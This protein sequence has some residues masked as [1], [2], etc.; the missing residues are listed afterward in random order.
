MRLAEN[1]A[2]AQSA[3]CTAPT[4]RE[5]VLRFAA[6]GLRIEAAALVVATCL[7]ALFRQPFWETVLYSICIST[8]CWLFIE[9]GRAAAAAWQRSRHRPVEPRSGWPGWTSMLTVVA[10]GGV[11]GYAV[12]NELANALTGSNSPGPFDAD[13]RQTLAILVLALVPALTITYFFQSRAIIARQREQVERAERQA[14]EQQLKL[15]ESQLEPH[16]LFNTLANLRALI[17][18]EPARAQAMLDR[19]IA[20]LRASLAGSRSDSQSLAAEF[21]RLRDYLALMEVR[22]GDRLATRFTLPAELAA[23]QIPPLLLQP[24]V[25]NSIRHGLELQ[26]EGGRIDIAAA[27]DG[28]ALVVTVRDTGAG[29][30]GVAPAAGGGFGL[31][32]VRERLATLYGSTASFALVPA[33]DG[34]GGMVATVR[35]PLATPT[36]ATA[37]SS[38]A[39]TCSHVR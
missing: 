33:A 24:I 26:R 29:A 14:A 20:F 2:M 22:M 28:D 3:L 38:S 18:V 9:A 6:R 37:G 15:I 7:W 4:A 5:V 12:G 21:A 8:M 10:V 11:L 16:M 1:A 36:A 39:S 23:A 25:E 31:D 35:L 17:A 27:R 13:P 34:G 30:S 32:H 19:L